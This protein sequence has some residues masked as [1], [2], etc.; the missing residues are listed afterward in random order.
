VGECLIVEMVNCCNVE[1]F[2]WGI[3]ESESWRIDVWY[4]RIK[5]LFNKNNLFGGVKIIGLE[6]D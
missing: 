2:D 6:N 3:G 4:M 1:M 5:V